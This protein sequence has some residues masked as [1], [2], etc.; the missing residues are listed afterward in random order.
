VER[1]AERLERLVAGLGGDHGVPPAGLPERE[2]LLA[3]AVEAAG[4][5]GDRLRVAAVLEK[6]VALEAQPRHDIGPDERLAR[7]VE[8]PEDVAGVDKRPW[9]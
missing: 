5:R 4:E 1:L 6:L 8:D 3:A 9:K 2:D 7:I